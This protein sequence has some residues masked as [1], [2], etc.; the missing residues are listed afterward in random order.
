MVQHAEAE[1]QS[2]CGEG[3]LVL[4]FEAHGGLGSVA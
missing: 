1:D 3:E 4:N 2:A